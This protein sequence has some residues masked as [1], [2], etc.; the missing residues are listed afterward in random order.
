VDFR[1]SVHKWTELELIRE[2]L[3]V[4]CFSLLVPSTIMPM[5]CTPHTKELADAQQS[6]SATCEPTIWRTIPVL[7][8]LQDTLQNMANT[9]KFAHF[10]TAIEAGVTNLHK[11]YSKTDDIDVYFICLGMYLISILMPL[12][13][14]DLVGVALEPNYKVTYAKDKWTAHFF[15]Q[16][17]QCLESMVRH[18]S[19]ISVNCIL[20]LHSLICIIAVVLPHR[21]LQS[22]LL[23]HL[24]CLLAKSR[25]AIIGCEALSNRVS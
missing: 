3:Q 1:L 20:I 19:L 2:V 8:C 5:C 15:K 24:P 22:H 11:W 13:V 10:S 12:N 16:G 25:M 7:K 9:S 21:L 23:L 18:S 6:F 17:M 14:T 4:S